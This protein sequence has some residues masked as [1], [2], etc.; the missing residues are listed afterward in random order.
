MKID[1]EY[2]SVGERNITKITINN[3]IGY[4]KIKLDDEEFNTRIIPFTAVKSIEFNE[5][6]R[7][8]VVSSI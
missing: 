5:E 6:P 2:L 4:V 3:E 1:D 8:L 7:R